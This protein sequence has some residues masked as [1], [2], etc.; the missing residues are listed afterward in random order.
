MF[1]DHLSF[2]AFLSRLTFFSVVNA[3]QM[4]VFYKFERKNYGRK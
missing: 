1:M 4:E 2:N 3:V